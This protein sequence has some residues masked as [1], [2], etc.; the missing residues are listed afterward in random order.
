MSQ[1]RQPKSSR[2]AHTRERILAAA[3]EVFARSGFHGARVA[4][5]AEQAGI[6]YGLVYHY[7]RN[8]DDILGAIFSERW[9]QYIEYLREV[10]RM[11]LAFP[12]RMRRLVHFWV[13]IFRREP[14][15]MTIM[16]NE[17]SRSY[18]FLESHDIGT[19]LQAF[20]AIEE[21]ISDARTRGEVR[22]DLDPQLATY[23]VVGAAEMILTGYVIGSLRRDSVESFARDEEQI[24]TMLLHGLT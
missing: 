13:E 3:T 1:A 5:I 17:I 22:S 2:S 21:I 15:L 16:I 11:P 4:D 8:K 24:V 19:V 14:D 20:D 18:E 6:A 12:E 23:I 10:G 7:F 9:Q